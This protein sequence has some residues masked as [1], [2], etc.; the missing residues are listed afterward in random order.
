MAMI[1]AYTC[2]VCAY[3]MVEPVEEGN[4]CPCCGTEFGYDDDLGV[5]YR[6]LRQLWIEHGCPWFSPVAA[7]PNDWEPILQMVE[8]DFE[9]DMAPDPD[10]SGTTSCTTSRIEG[11]SYALVA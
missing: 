1:N 10:R 7:M 2:P 4:I 9:F 5:T 3:S 11:G 6:Q 8:A